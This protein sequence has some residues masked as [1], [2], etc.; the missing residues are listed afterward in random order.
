MIDT[1][2][3]TVPQDKGIVKNGKKT[4]YYAIIDHLMHK[5]LLKNIT[6]PDFG[7]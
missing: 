5:D 6:Y 1:V 7:R 2:Q 4:P 3:L